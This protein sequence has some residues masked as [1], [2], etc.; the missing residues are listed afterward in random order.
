MRNLRSVAVEFSSYSVAS[1]VRSFGEE[2]EASGLGDGGARDALLEGGSTSLDILDTE[3]GISPTDESS[4]AAE[5][6]LAMP[7]RSVGP[8]IAPDGAMESP[9]KQHRDLI[10]STTTSVNISGGMRVDRAA[11]DAPTRD[12]GGR[13]VPNWMRSDRRWDVKRAPASGVVR[14][15]GKSGRDVY[16]YSSDQN[17]EYGA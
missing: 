8:S 7:V 11:V 3:W 5:S 13:Y 16:T 9:T 10:S 1:A 2:G 12:V 14:R 15:S 17:N 4:I 6:L